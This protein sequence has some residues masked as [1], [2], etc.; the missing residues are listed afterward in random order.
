[1]KQIRNFCIIA[2]IDHGKSTL[3]D[4]LLELT[5]TIEKR[6]MKEQV[7][8]QMDL[9]REKGITIKLQPV[10]MNFKKDNIEYL[11]NLIDTPGHVDFT[12]EV[13]RSIAACEGALLVVDA[14]KGI[15]AQTLANLY[16]AIEH[17][18]VIIPVINKI[19]LPNADVD[20][21]AE[22]I[23][24]ILGAKE[25]DI[26]CISAKTGENVNKILDEIVAK[27]PAPRGDLRNPLKALIFDSDYD[28]FRGVR[29]FIRMYA[30]KVKKGDK[31]FFS[32]T[33]KASE[34]FGI[35]IFKPN[36]V[37]KD[38]LCAGEVGFLD[39]GLKEIEH[40]RVGDTVAANLSI[41]PL[42]GY[43]KPIS[44]VYSSL[45][46]V[47]ADDFA[48]FKEA[49][50]K[51]ALND[52]SLVFEPINSKAL[53]FGFR[54]GFLG[55]LHLEIA[56]ERLRREFGLDLVVTSPSVVY[57]VKEGNKFINI[58]NPQDFKPG[59]EEIQEPWVL[60]EI[61]TPKDYMG[62]IMN[63]AEKR[64]GD[65][66][67]SEFITEER[68]ILKYELPLYNVITDFYDKL[69]SVSSG[70]ASLSYELR[71]Y[72]KGDLVR[73]DILVNKEKV[74]ALSEIVHKS[75]AEI[76]ARLI[77]KKLKDKIPS[78]LFQVPIQACIDGQIVAREN[79]KALKKDVTAKLYGGDVTRKM[80]LLEK[81]RKGKK[82]M[83]TVGNVSIPSSV[84][85]EILKR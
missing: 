35:G 67:A 61:V 34:V 48:E 2:H 4:R 33:K 1:M 84:F 54:A 17:N 73:I 75:E 11:L 19:D 13:S 32:A 44:V 43:K 45:F 69:K 15:Q 53:G 77:V 63:L 30:G 21:V 29:A 40:V 37:S 20:K 23:E 31:V 62:K 5:G 81:Q 42:A 71:E 26:I 16:M 18:L 22:E 9:E 50:S 52:S 74:D 6:K 7:L 70:Y 79:I 24:K 39:T 78:Q 65:Y 27:I 8:D 12:Y 72:R 76:R 3:A 49:L 58:T 57:K 36:R 55:L 38:S 83:E 25:S 46:P 82:R 28:E 56:I 85:L 51:L 66:K 64:R 59:L 10:A 68:V 41:A 80:K 47:N 60:V 14:T